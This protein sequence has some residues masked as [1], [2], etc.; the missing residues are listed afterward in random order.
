MCTYPAI[1]FHYGRAGSTGAGGDCVAE[2]LLPAPA[3]LNVI[4]VSPIASCPS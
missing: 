3:S 4:I 1:R 2:R